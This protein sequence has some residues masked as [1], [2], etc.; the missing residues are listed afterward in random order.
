MNVGGGG[1]A[2]K[3]ARGGGGGAWSAA[4]KGMVA[5]MRSSRAFPW[6]QYGRYARLRGTPENIASVGRT[7]RS[8]TPAQRQMRTSHGYTGRGGY[9]R[10]IHGVYNPRGYDGRGIYT[11]RGGFSWNDFVS[12]IKDV[13]SLI[14]QPILKAAESLIV[15]KI[16]NSQFKKNDVWL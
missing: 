7:W 4:K 13:G 11:G 16:G 15:K 1:P 2:R 6:R 14:G 12:G 10:A 9:N 5:S 3:R 8:A